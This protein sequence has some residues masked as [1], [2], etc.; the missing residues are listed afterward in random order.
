MRPT[1]TKDRVRALLAAGTVLGLGAVGTLAAWTDSSTAT[2][3]TFS[4]GTIDLRLGSGTT[5]PNPFSFT[6]FATSNMAPGSATTATLQVNNSGTLPFTY[7]VSGSATNSGAGSDQL[8][9]ALTLQIYAGTTC[10]GTVLNSPATF[11]FSAL[12]TT[13]TLAAGT[14]ETLCFRAALPTGADTALQGKSTVGTFVF[15]AT[16]T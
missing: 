14:N 6:T 3:G 11:T 10:S 4:T 16:N 12:G 5:D 8:G 2:T 7:N 1:R 9:S 15:T 13:R